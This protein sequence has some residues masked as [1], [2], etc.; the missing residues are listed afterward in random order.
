MVTVKDTEIEDFE[1]A[2]KLRRIEG[3]RELAVY[4][5]AQGIAVIPQEW[6][7]EE[8]LALGGF[9][10][11]LGET[12][13]QV[14]A[15]IVVLDDESFLEYCSQI[16]VS[17]SLDGGIVLN[18]IWDSADSDFRNRKYVPF[19]K[20]NI[21]QEVLLDLGETGNKAKISVLAYTQETPVLREEYEDYGL[22]HFLPVSVWENIS[23]QLG[24]GGDC[25]IR[26]FAKERE[27]LEGLCVLEDAVMEVL[28]PLYAAK[29]EN[30]IQEKLA[31]DQMIRG[32][33]IILGAF[34]VLLAIIGIANV[35][36]NTLGFLCQRK[37]EFARYMSIGVTPQEMKK[38][39]C[40][41]ALMIAGRPLLVTLPL[42]L[43]FVQFAAKASQLNPMVFWAE[44]PVAPILLFG[45]AIVGFVAFAYFIG[46]KRIL[47]CDLNDELKNDALV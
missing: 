27:S 32:M 37:R 40:I 10:A 17:P 36:S 39:F 11:L 15:P 16:G 31:N 8:L 24:S 1:L 22:V 13:E 9:K 7:S 29:S 26:I 33:V 23:G 20:E 30:R 3:I 25:M 19:V 45:L 5:K 46:G 35:F 38:M 14:K 6:Q 47:N 28:K 34:C 2:E 42:T 43:L 41:E 44:A 18:Q 4:Q 12:G 21:K